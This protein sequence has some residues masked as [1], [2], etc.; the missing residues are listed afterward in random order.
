M[1][2]VA[3]VTSTR[4]RASW[5][6]LVSRLTLSHGGRVPFCTPH[7]A[8]SMLTR[9]LM[10]TWKPLGPWT[11]LLCS[12][13]WLGCQRSPAA[14]PP[15]AIS[16]AQAAE[17]AHVLALQA[18]VC[19]L[20]PMVDEAPPGSADA[21]GSLEPAAASC[22]DVIELVHVP[23]VALHG[24]DKR[25]VADVRHAIAE[26]DRDAEA[27]GLL[28]FFDRGVDAV[29]EGRMAH[30]ALL[31]P[32]LPSGPSLDRLRKHP[33]LDALQQLSLQAPDPLGAEARALATLIAASHFVNQ[34]RWQPAGQAYAAEP[35]FAIMFGKEFAAGNRTL[36]PWER[37][38][39]SAA[40]Q[41]GPE[42]STTSQSN[43]PEGRAVGGGPIDPTEN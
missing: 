1:K 31:S 7:L 39:A 43:E 6:M 29:A 4:M 10:R 15:N 13:A 34:A 2:P 20:G 36:D 17:N 9:R 27:K 3:P 5:H 41:V 30:H 37:Y 28:N 38:L 22:V 11:A 16:P 40:R 19:M 33:K 8:L 24:V 26:G 23:P 21:S 35:L 12:A 42:S 14:A 25:A 18:L 32:P